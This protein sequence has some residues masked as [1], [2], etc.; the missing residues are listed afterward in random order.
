MWKGFPHGSAVK[1][2]VWDAGDVGDV[3]SIPGWGRSPGWGHGNPFQ[4]SCLENPMEGGARQAIVQRVAKSWPLLKRLSTHT[5]DE[6]FSRG[7]TKN[8]YSCIL[9]TVYRETFILLLVYFHTYLHPKYGH[10]S[11]LCAKSVTSNSYLKALFIKPW[12]HANLWVMW[13]IKRWMTHSSRSSQ[14]HRGVRHINKHFE[15]AEN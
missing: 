7:T 1:E 11:C 13:W 9:N 8:S 2:S 15:S 5:R 6:N 4:Y 12:P 10:I 14:P 3:G